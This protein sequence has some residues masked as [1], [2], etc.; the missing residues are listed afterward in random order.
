M[1]S[2]GGAKLAAL[3]SAIGYM[4][5]LLAPGVDTSP[6][7][8]LI[9]RPQEPVGAPSLFSPNMAQFII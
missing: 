8:G 5:D 1:M 3:P 4:A 7:K 9:L 6:F 2:K